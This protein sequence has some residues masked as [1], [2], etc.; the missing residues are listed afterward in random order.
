MI[1]LKFFDRS[2]NK[3]IEEI[4][5][6]GD[7][8]NDL[9][10]DNCIAK[11]LLKVIAKGPFISWV[12]GKWFSLFFTKSRIEPFIKNN[13]IDPSEFAKTDFS[14]FND[15]FTRKLLK[16][17]RPICSNAHSIVM[18]SDGAYIAFEDID[19]LKILSIKEEEFSLKSLLLND[20]LYNKFYGGSGFLCR[21]SPK[22]YHRFHFPIDCV[23]SKPRLIN[24]YYYSVNPVALKTN[25]NILSQN[26]R[27]LTLLKSDR[28]DVLFIE[29]GAT[30]VSSINQ[31]YVPD[32]KVLKGDEKGCFSLGASSVLVLF[33][34]NQISLDKDIVKYSQEGIWTKGKMGEQIAHFL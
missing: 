30:L 20:E 16:E 4:E 27:V 33:Q 17:A 11:V 23:P 5:Y 9:Y 29:I 15:F 3:V 18:P 1:K 26:K 6:K 22:D 28:E 13:K 8:V 24:G 10:R 2:K 31:T 14:S 19:D 12:W 32:Q 25:I 21:L 34:K 7:I